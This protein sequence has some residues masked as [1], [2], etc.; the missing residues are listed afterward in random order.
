MILM[1]GDVWNLSWQ[2]HFMRY[3][4]IC[5][6]CIPTN[7]DFFDYFPLWNI[8]VSRVAH[9]RHWNADSGPIR[10]RQIC[11]RSL[12]RFWVMNEILTKM[13][14]DP[15]MLQ[16]QPTPVFSFDWLSYI[17]LWLCFYN[18]LVL[19][20]SLPL[21]MFIQSFH[22][23][24][25]YLNL[26]ISTVIYE[27]LYTWTYCIAHLQPFLIIHTRI[28]GCLLYLFLLYYFPWSTSEIFHFHYF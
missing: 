5:I 7:N 24:A 15:S 4:F 19:V 1:Y 21:L 18:R 14:F 16:P 22:W 3:A 12:D 2:I 8:E 11:K 27:S 25:A 9:F 6:A 23:A 26:W 20:S 13:N 10:S 28:F 17:F